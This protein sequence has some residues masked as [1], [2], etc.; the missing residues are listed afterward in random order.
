MNF[1]TA[2]TRPSEILYACIRDNDLDRLRNL[3]ASGQHSLI[4]AQSP[5]GTPLD[6]AV[7]CDNIA[8]AE[9][10]LGAGENPLDDGGDSDLYTTAMELA[11]LKGQ[12][13]MSR[14][15]R[16]AL[17]SRRLLD[18]DIDGDL[19]ERRGL[20]A[21]C[22]WKAAAYGHGD[23]VADY[24]DWEALPWSAGSKE[25]A[26]RQ[27]AGRWENGVVDV[28]LSKANYDMEALEKA[29]S[30]AVNLKFTLIDE[31]RTGVSYEEADHTKQY[32]VV[33]RLLDAGCDANGLE[34]GTPLLHL[35]ISSIVLQGSL[36][37]LLERGIDPDTKHERGRTALQIL[38]CPIPLY[39]RGPRTVLHEAGIRLL[40]SKGANVTTGD[41]EGETPLCWAAMNCSTDIFRLYLSHCVD[42]DAA[43]SSRNLHGET[44]LHYAAAGGQYD[45]IEFLLGCGVDV[46]A[47]SDNGW[48]PLICALTPTVL[49]QLPGRFGGRTKTEIDAM[50]SAKLLLSHG[51]DPT[52]VTSEGWTTIHFVGSYT[53]RETETDAAAL[54]RELLARPSM[55]T[56]NTPAQ[57]FDRLWLPRI[58]DSAKRD[59]FGSEPWGFRIGKTLARCAAT[60]TAVVK[61]G[62]TPLHWAAERGAVGVVKV[63][64][65]AGADPT[66]RD[67]V[68]AT[69]LK[70][71]VKSEL[72]KYNEDIRE[73][74]R[75]IL[76]DGGY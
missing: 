21:R 36:R 54:T 15:F 13:G 29:L 39:G 69:P 63:L 60:E 6:V 40:L 57:G 73:E 68:G 70:L 75:V 12:R 11:A 55:P 27:A 45:T 28:L 53:N 9:I 16:D 67:S 2:F 47:I 23:L 64:V 59:L 48:T 8:A 30:A 20:L 41:D 35:A 19:E 65:A 49:G 32:N 24:L 46:N 62:L 58:S 72:L 50:K 61:H 52:V 3:L 17:E 38:T 43:L 22:L 42:R 26:L 18:M 25:V 66:A 14:L 37:A 74:L 34:R 7:R 56:L 44:L 4:H 71:A 1:E 5:W 10:L 51:A 33:T 31:E 76:K